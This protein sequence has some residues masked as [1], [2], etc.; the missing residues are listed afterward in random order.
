MKLS[1]RECYSD[2]DWSHRNP[3]D[4]KF[5]ANCGKSRSTLMSRLASNRTVKATKMQSTLSRGP[6]LTM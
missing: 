1:S 3:S 4:Q 5:W 2:D 6:G